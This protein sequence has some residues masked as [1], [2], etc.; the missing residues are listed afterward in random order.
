MNIMSYWAWHGNVIQFTCGLS[1]LLCVR[2]KV[3]NNVKCRQHNMFWKCLVEFLAAKGSSTRALVFCLSVCGQNWIS[4]CLVS[5]WQLMTAY[6]SLW[7]LMTAYDSF[8]QLLTAFDSLWQLMT[9]YDSL[10]QLMIAYDNLW[11]RMTT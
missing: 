1:F 11:Q 8:W 10:W 7:Q 2:I 6:D 5:L 9:A 4:H 3:W